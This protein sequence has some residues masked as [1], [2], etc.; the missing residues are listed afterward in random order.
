MR[1]DGATEVIMNRSGQAIAI[2]ALLIPGAPRTVRAAESRSDLMISDRAD[3][4]TDVVEDE[5]SD[6]AR[7]D[8]PNGDHSLWT[9]ST[10]RHNTPVELSRHRKSL[11][12]PQYWAMPMGHGLYCI[13]EV[14]PPVS[15]KDWT[16][17][18]HN[19]CVAV[20]AFAGGAIALGVISHFTV[21]LGNFGAG[22]TWGF[23]AFIGTIM[24]DGL[25]PGAEARPASPADSPPI[26]SV[27]PSP[28]DLWGGV[29]CLCPDPGCQCGAHCNCACGEGG[30]GV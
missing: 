25:C 11:L 26:G 30:G 12:A 27:I 21:G 8:S 6:E 4:H 1:R 20:A 19:A 7:H 10:K 16:A 2:A 15:L 29:P 14:E 18:E 13:L 3:V 23:G 24:G 17:Q 5:E 22:F 9:R 28:A